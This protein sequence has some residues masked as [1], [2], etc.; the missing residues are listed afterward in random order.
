MKLASRNDD[1]FGTVLGA[2]TKARQRLQRPLGLG[3]EHVRV[4]IRD[5]VGPQVM[6]QFIRSLTYRS[7]IHPT[8][9]AMIPTNSTQMRART[10]RVLPLAAASAFRH[11]ARYS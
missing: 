11:A 2:L 10:R 4:H 6:Y 7:L 3:L 8:R 9:P 1:H 5:P